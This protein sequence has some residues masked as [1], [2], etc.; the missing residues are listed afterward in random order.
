MKNPYKKDWIRAYEKHFFF[1]RIYQVFIFL[2]YIMTDNNLYIQSSIAHGL[3]SMVRNELAK[4]SAQKQDEFIEEYK[5][6]SKSLPVAYILL[7]VVC[8]CHYGYVK[9][10]W[11][12]RLYRLSFG[13]FFFWAVIDLFRL[14]WLIEEYNKEMA[15]EV[16]RNLKV[17]S[18]Q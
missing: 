9:K 10:R 16:M 18:H 13:W 12:Q 6:K 7:L 17:I 15:I 14:P 4:L 8:G 1:I 2:L 5:R 11:I 3:P